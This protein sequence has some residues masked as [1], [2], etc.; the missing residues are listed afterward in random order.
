[1]VCPVVDWMSPPLPKADAE[2]LLASEDLAHPFAGSC[3]LEH[4]IEEVR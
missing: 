2:E 4:R 3:R 1:M